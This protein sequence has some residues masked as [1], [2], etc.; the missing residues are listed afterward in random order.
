MPGE[1]KRGN[2]TGRVSDRLHTRREAIIEIALVLGN[3]NGDKRATSQN[4]DESMSVG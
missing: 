2:M 1:E 4:N 3:I